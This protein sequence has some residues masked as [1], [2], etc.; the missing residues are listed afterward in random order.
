MAGGFT[1]MVGEACPVEAGGRPSTSPCGYHWQ[2]RTCKSVACAYVA[3]MLRSVLTA[4]ARSIRPRDG[5]LAT[6]WERVLAG[7][8]AEVEG[9]G[10]RTGLCA[11]PWSV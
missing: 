10:R 1:V 5:F 7:V 2:A 8:A 9:R 6:W 4:V 3:D 11:A